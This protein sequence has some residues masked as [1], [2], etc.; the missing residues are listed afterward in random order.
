MKI[1]KLNDLGMKEFEYFVLNLRKGNSQN[2]PLHLLEAPPYSEE[3][4]FDIEIEPERTFS[5]RFEIGVYLAGLFKDID[6]QKHIGDRGFW[7]WFALVWFDQLCPRKN[8][9]R[10]PSMPYNYVLS[11]DYKHRPRHAIY[12]TWQLVDRYG[13]DARF[14]LCKD[15]TTRGEMTEVLMARQSILSSR[16]VIQLASQLYFDPQSGGFKKGS[17]ARKSAGCVARYI[18]W[19]QQ[20]QLTFDIFS[21]TTDELEQL[22]PAEFDRFRA[23]IPSKE[24]QL[25]K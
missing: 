24:L 13:D 23:D 15:P 11:A 2:T 25:A 4:N 17:A 20:L 1:R 8:K 18:S 21:I 16:A 5:S 22:L 6:L 3:V 10:K 19:I 12:M 9:V 14:L 7:T